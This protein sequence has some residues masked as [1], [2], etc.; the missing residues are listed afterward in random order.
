VSE[1]LRADAL[2]IGTSAAVPGH[3]HGT[4]DVV[5]DHGLL[6]PASLLDDDHTQ[7]LPLT[8]IRPMT[9]NLAMG[10]R[11][12][13]GLANGSADTDAAA[14]GQFKA[15]LT[16]AVTAGNG[17]T[18]GGALPSTLNVVAGH[19]LEA[20]VDAIGLKG[21]STY[22]TDWDQAIY[23]GWYMGADAANSPAAEGGW[24][25]G[26]AIQHNTDWVTQIAFPFANNFYPTVLMT[27]AKGNGGWG[28]WSRL[29]N[30]P[31]SW[32]TLDNFI[33]L[34]HGGNW[35]SSGL[36]RWAV[37]N[38]KDGTPGASDADEFRIQRY[39]TG[40]TYTGNLMTGSEAGAVKFPGGHSLLVQAMAAKTTVEADRAAT[41]GIVDA[42]I[43]Q[44]LINAGVMPVAQMRTND[45]VTGMEIGEPSPDY[46]P[47]P[48]EEAPQPPGPEVD[49]SGTLGT[50]Q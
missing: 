42:M 36:S 14:Y 3:V 21:S 34:R 22:L 2:R 20:G 16:A 37:G 8:G 15:L 18:G 49:P 47:S 50:P 9:G 27:R 4:E 30:Y 17:L 35:A 6:I 46:D 32:G 39:D 28:Y 33:T 40:G 19:M 43:R 10:A 31:H 44:A 13:T 5:A 25:Y 41:V 26:I 48:N 12:I 1:T 24:W 23:N 45:S 7:Y 11:K 29:L 38:K